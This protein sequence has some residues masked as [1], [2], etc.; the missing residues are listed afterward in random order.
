[1]AWMN[2]QSPAESYL[3]RFQLAQFFVQTAQAEV[4]GGEVGVQPQGRLEIR[5]G[6]GYASLLLDQPSEG[7]VRLRAVGIDLEHLLVDGRSVRE[8]LHLEIVLGEQLKVLVRLRLQLASPQQPRQRLVVA[9]LPVAG[10][11]PDWHG[12]ASIRT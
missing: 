3:G 4:G 7:V 11:R 2:L 1:M 9:T 8:P 12:P 6:L 5:A 10:Q